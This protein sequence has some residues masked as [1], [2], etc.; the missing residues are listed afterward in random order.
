VT[1]VNG[2]GL[3]RKLGF[4]QGY[5]IV[6]VHVADLERVPTVPVS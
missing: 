4:G 6:I 5:L 2:F 1:L 3:R